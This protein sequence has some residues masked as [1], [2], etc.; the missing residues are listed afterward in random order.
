MSNII[1]VPRETPKR[2]FLDVSRGTFLLLSQLPR[3]LLYARRNSERS[4]LTQFCVSRE[5]NY[6]SCAMHEL[7]LGIKVPRETSDSE[8]R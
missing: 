6:Y 8:L 2:Y 7:L 3:V 4:F 1:N 5:T